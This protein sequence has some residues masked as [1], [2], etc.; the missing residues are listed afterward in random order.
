[1]SELETFKNSLEEVRSS[2]ERNLSDNS[3]KIYIRYYNKLRGELNEDLHSI[4]EKS[5]L[6]MLDNM[7]LNNINTFNQYLNIFILIRRLYGLND[8][9]LIKKRNANKSVVKEQVK[10]NFETKPIAITY[11]E[12]ILE[13][14]KLYACKNW[15]NYIINWLLIHKGLRNADI[16]LDIVLLKRNTKDTQ[17]NYIWIKPRGLCILYINVYKTAGTYG[18]K[19]IIIN[20]KAF[21]KA[22]R[23]FHKL[24]EPLISNSE[25]VGYYVKKASILD[26]GEA[27][28][29]KII[30]KH[31]WNNKEML[32]DLSNTR[33][34]DI[35]TILANYKS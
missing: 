18:M 35:A 13:L 6:D 22:I 12:L 19:E 15:R 20:D 32:T 4:S 29:F 21:N 31:F 25:G 9:L 10:I 16:N 28:I 7:Q 8:T 23:A 34:T 5:A 26:L 2:N 24:N 3:K 14:Q 11:D 33:G 27:T 30:V 17:K 1:M